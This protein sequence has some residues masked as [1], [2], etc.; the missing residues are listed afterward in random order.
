MYVSSVPACLMKVAQDY[1]RTARAKGLSQRR[2]YFKH[3]LKNALIPMITH[4][5][6]QIPF[7]ITGSLL[8]ENFFQIPGLGNTVIQA[9]TNNDYPVLKAMVFL[10]AVLFLIFNLFTDI[11][12]AIADPRVRLGNA[13]Q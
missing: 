1:V 7:L 11:C 9:V 5:V 2:V 10:G 4:V 6:I 8:L 12:Y 13:R 3:V